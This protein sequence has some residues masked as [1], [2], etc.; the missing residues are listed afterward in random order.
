MV[1]IKFSKL[2]LGFI[3][4]KSDDDITARQEYISK[5][6][7]FILA[8]SHFI[9]TLV[10][11][12][13]WIVLRDDSGSGV[14]SLLSGV[15]VAVFNIIITYRGHWRTSRTITLIY[16]F[17]LTVLAFFIS[18]TRTPIILMLPLLLLI[19]GFA[20]NRSL[21]LVSALVLSAMYVLFDS[22]LIPKGIVA[23]IRPL[24]NSINNFIAIT[25]ML[26]LISF[27]IYLFSKQ[28]DKTLERSF[29]AVRD[30]QQQLVRSEQLASIGLLASGISH[31]YNNINS[32]ALGYIELLLDDG[33]VDADVKNKLKKVRRALLRSGRI[34]ENLMAF[35]KP[36]AQERSFT[37]LNDVVSSMIDLLSYKFKNDGIDL[38][39]NKGTLPLIHVNKKQ[40]SQ[41]ILNLLTNAEHALKNRAEKKLSIVTTTGKGE[42]R[43]AISDTGCGIS[44]EYLPNVFKPF[45]STKSSGGYH[46]MPGKSISPGL[47][48][49]VSMSIIKEHKGDMLVSSVQGKGTI[50][51]LVLPVFIKQSA[52]VSLHDNKSSRQNPAE[53]EKNILILDDEEDIRTILSTA[54]T[55]MGHSVL[56][57]DDGYKGLEYISQKKFDVALVDLHMPIMEGTDFLEKVIGLPREKRPAIVVVTGRSTKKLEEEKDALGVQAIVHKPFML[58]D[59]Q[60]VIKKV[61]V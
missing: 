18:G 19:L 5:I 14:L 48:L 44:E 10:M 34:S 57:T 50:F 30:T 60:S 15:P 12:I 36:V 53:P 51:T 17:L 42:I 55:A 41:V 45:F 27:L 46:N 38:T 37:D 13:R 33:K 20:Y 21:S 16:I 6:L 59:I 39:F 40:I 29:R 9:L 49:S 22:Y 61:A 24:H 35:S 26:L 11:S 3:R 58:S 4:P 52:P 43:L 8:A 32:I 54:L 25:F 23:P 2:W 1:N 7:V 56:S 31:E 28:V 47:G